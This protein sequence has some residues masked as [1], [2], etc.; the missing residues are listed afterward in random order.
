MQSPVRPAAPPAPEVALTITDVGQL[1]K[2]A[3]AGRTV[4]GPLPIRLPF[5]SFGPCVF[6]MSELTAEQSRPSIE[7]SYKRKSRW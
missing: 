7:F 3:V 6:L 2:D 5:P 4:T 1:R